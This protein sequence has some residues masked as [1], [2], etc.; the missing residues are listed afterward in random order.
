MQ[1]LGVTEIQAFGALMVPTQ[2]L[3]PKEPLYSHNWLMHLSYDNPRRT[4]MGHLRGII[5]TICIDPPFISR[6]VLRNQSVVTNHY[7]GRVTMEI[8]SRKNGGVM[9]KRIVLITQMNRIVLPSNV[10]LLN[11]RAKL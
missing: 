10:L 7:F 2:S 11:S 1:I 6:T 5:C 8:V 9:L 4:Y 3:G